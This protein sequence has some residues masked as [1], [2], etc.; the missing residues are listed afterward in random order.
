MFIWTS[1]KLPPIRKIF[2]QWPF[3]LDY[4]PLFP[5]TSGFKLRIDLAEWQAKTQR[6]PFL[7]Y[8][9]SFNDS[10]SHFTRRFFQARSGC[11]TSVS[12]WDYSP[13]RSITDFQ[14]LIV[15]LIKQQSINL[16]QQYQSANI[17]ADQTSIS[18]STIWH[19]W[20]QWR[21]NH[22]WRLWNHDYVSSLQDICLPDTTLNLIG[23]IASKRP[24]RAR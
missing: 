24:F 19:W 1:D 6:E 5:R 21:E 10:K 2:R 15:I 7:I 12:D 4:V 18:R 23:M 14:I 9:D 22:D 13:F 8:Q 20:K 17:A 3:S 11:S 16:R